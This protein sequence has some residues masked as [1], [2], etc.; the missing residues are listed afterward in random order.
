MPR[1]PSRRWITSSPHY[2]V[3]TLNHHSPAVLKMRNSWPM[4]LYMCVWLFVEVLLCPSELKLHLPLTTLCSRSGNHW[5]SEADSKI[6]TYSLLYVRTR[7]S[8]TSRWSCVAAPS[9]TTYAI[10]LPLCLLALSHYT[11]KIF[12]VEAMPIF[13]SINRLIR[14]TPRAYA[15]AKY[16]ME[17]LT[18]VPDCS[19]H[20]KGLEIDIE[21]LQAPQNY[22]TC[23]LPCVEGQKYSVCTYCT[24]RL[25]GLKPN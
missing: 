5:K 15:S 24:W 11:S 3:I 1:S 25:V 7:S 10:L 22:L 18:N 6:L 13:Y 2:F 23:C 17:F 12:Y 19:A 14:R 21:M 9:S 20:I 4:L 8:N 16:T